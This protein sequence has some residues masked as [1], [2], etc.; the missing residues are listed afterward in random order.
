MIILGSWIC[1]LAFS[2]APLVGWSSYGLEGTNVTCSVKWQSSLPIFTFYFLPL[3]VICFCYYKIHQVAKQIVAN[4][5]H[6]S[7]LGMAS[8]QALLNK[9][10]NLLFFSYNIAAFLLPWTPYATVSFLQILRQK[11]NP[12]ATT[13]CRSRFFFFLVS[14]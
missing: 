2:V 9:H 1:S 7:G 6:R 11:I 3:A 14:L 4:T 10:H 13:V 5:S 12:V 8:R